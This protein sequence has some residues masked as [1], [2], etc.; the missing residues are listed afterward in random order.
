MHYKD[1]KLSVRKQLKGHG[2]VKSHLDSY[3]LQSYSFIL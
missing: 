3:A 2:G 1:I